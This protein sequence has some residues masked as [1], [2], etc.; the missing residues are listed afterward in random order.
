[1]TGA[2]PRCATELAEN[3]RIVMITLDNPPDNTVTPAM[4]ERLSEALDVAVVEGGPDMVVLTGRGRVFS[5]GFDVDVVRSHRD[6]VSH[7]ASLAM[8]NDVV[9]RLESCPKP[10]IAAVNGH[11]FGAGLELAMACHFRLCAEKA[12]LGLPELSRGLIP[13]LGGVPRLAG[14]VGRAKALEL[15]TLGDLITAEEAHRVGLVNRVL[16]RSEFMEAVLGFARAILT[17]DQAL[18]REVIRL[19]PAVSRTRHQESLMESV[20]SAVRVAGVQ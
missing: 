4:L 15:I 3:G 20:D 11:C 18:V 17:V 8:C 2:S 5:K 19:S 13:G 10:V 14:L 12:R 16:P 9:N 7:R 6:R 1:M